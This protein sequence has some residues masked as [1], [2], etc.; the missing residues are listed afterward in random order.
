MKMRRLISKRQLLLRGRKGLSGVEAFVLGAVARAVATVLVYPFTRALRIQQG[1]AAAAQTSLLGELRSV[2][3]EQGLAGLYLGIVPD[4]SRG[5]M[6]SAL[7]S[8]IKER[9]AAT[10]ALLLQPPQGGGGD[11]RAKR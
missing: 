5:V 11:P 6:S 8:S 7:R 3:R 10:L 4:I 1:R 2:V 9:L